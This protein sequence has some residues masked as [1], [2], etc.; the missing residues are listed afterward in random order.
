MREEG[1]HSEKLSGTVKNTGAVLESAEKLQP[2]HL[3]D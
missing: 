2:K 3:A 1:S